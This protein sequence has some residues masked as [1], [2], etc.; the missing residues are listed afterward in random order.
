MKNLEI[1]LN[2]NYDDMN[3]AEKRAVIKELYHNQNKSWREIAKQLN[4]YAVKVHREAKKF[5]IESRDKS[6]AQKIALSEGKVD[7]PTKGKGHSEKTKEKISEA[8]WEYWK[9][10]PDDEKKRRSEISS[11]N[12]ENLPEHEKKEFKKA[13]N[14]AVRAASKNGSKLENFLFEELTHARL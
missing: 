1:L 9:N 11:K 7:H 2:L 12:W 13:G 5:G 8:Q 6:E 14:A 4:T 10:M 3:D